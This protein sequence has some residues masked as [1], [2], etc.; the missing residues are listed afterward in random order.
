MNKIKLT[1]T[2]LLLTLITLR[3][4][5]QEP[6]KTDKRAKAKVERKVDDFTSQITINSP[7]RSR[8]ELSPAILYKY[9]GKKDTTYYLSLHAHGASVVVDGTGVTILFTDGRK[10]EKPGKIDVE[11]DNSHYGGYRYDAFIPLTQ[12]DLQ[13]LS[14]KTIDKF[15]LYIFDT[16]LGRSKGEE[17]KALVNYIMAAN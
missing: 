11:V 2:L 17:F 3:S 4:A 10:L 13:L 9:I 8:G 15:R 16:N 5:A 6:S 1:L 7:I 14:T 12:S